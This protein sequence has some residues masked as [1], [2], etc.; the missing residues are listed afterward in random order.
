MAIF[1]HDTDIADENVT[2]DVSILKAELFFLLSLLTPSRPSLTFAQQAA[3]G[4][5]LPFILCKNCNETDRLKVLLALQGDE[6]LVGAIAKS[7]SPYVAG[8]VVL[9]VVLRLN[10]CT[11][12]TTP[13]RALA[14]AITSIYRDN[15]VVNMSRRQG[16]EGRSLPPLPG[17]I[18]NSCCWCVCVF[19]FKNLVFRSFGASSVRMMS[20]V[21]NHVVLCPC[22][23]LIVGARR[24]PFQAFR[25]CRPD[26]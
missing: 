15:L 11:F 3:P 19:R 6:S 8:S 21:V 13:A 18:F 26:P 14:H 16:V 10:A 17:V 23:A 2:H 5:S 25:L 24:F 7:P 1:V 4:S 20:L 12:A 22:I 9:V